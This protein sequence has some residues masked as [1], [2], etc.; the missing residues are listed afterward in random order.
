MDKFEFVKMEYLTLKEEIKET[1]NR[2]FKLA[3][4][5]VVGMPA[6]YFI[7]K[8]HKIEALILS[9]PVLICTLLLL[10]LSESRALMRCGAYIK[11]SI[12]SKLKKE[13]ECDLL[14]LDWEHWLEKT[15]EGKSES[16]RRLVDK[17]L[18]FFFYLLFFYYYIASVYLA[19]DLADSRFGIIGFAVCLAIYI[20]GG[21]LFIGFLVRLF[22][23]FH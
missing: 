2:I 15:P 11:E 3:G 9:L 20:S 23:N 4:L 21:I 7:A 5:G 13:K 1:K 19:T 8:T 14:P 12:E 18:T 16:E 22:C 6:A 17:L 10:F